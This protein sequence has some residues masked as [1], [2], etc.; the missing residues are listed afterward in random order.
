MLTQQL[1]LV[2]AVIIHIKYSPIICGVLGL[3][4]MFNAVANNGG[5][6]LLNAL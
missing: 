1:H 5:Y 3:R 2:Y 4:L 6:L